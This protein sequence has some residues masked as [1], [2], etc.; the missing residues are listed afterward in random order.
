M[1][2][3]HQHHHPHLASQPQ[4][5][6][7]DAQLGE[8][9]SG[10]LNHPYVA[11]PNHHAAHDLLALREDHYDADDLKRL[12]SAAYSDEA[13]PHD[14]RLKIADY[15]M[16]EFLQSKGGSKGT[17]QGLYNDCTNFAVQ[18]YED[19]LQHLADDLGFTPPQLVARLLYC[20]DVELEHEMV[21][22]IEALHMELTADDEDEAEEGEDGE[23]P[24]DSQQRRATMARV[25]AQHAAGTLAPDL[26]AFILSIFGPQF[27]TSGRDGAERA[28]DEEEEGHHCS[29]NLCVCR[30]TVCGVE[31]TLC[32]RCLQ[33]G[34]VVDCPNCVRLKAEGGQHDGK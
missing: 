13:T 29:E 32:V 11:N 12:M 23:D 15:M 21:E 20:L 31:S 7:T 10:I 1:A 6:H 17:D 8:K 18:G 26:E 16:T 2:S 14:V 28:G 3:H 34:K 24:G 4:P 27:F 19:L 9:L 30:C 25:Q 33:S 5:K 22:E